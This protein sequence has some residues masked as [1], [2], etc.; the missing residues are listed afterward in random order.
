MLFFIIMIFLASSFTLSSHP[1]PGIE[2]IA[3]DINNY[4]DLKHPPQY[5]AN[6][7]MP[8][9]HSKRCTIIEN[10]D[11]VNSYFSGVYKTVSSSNQILVS[12]PCLGTDS[13]GN[14]LGAYFENIVCANRSGMHYVAVAKVWEPREKD[15]PSLFLQQLPFSIE[16]SH[17]LD[18]AAVKSNVKSLCR[19]VGSCHERSNAVWIKGLNIIRPILHNALQNYLKLSDGL[20]C[21]VVSGSDLSS[22]AVGTVLPLIPDAAIHYRC[23]D[24]YVGH[25]GFLPFRAFKET[26]PQ[27]VRTIFVLAENRDRKTR[28]KRHLAAKCDAIFPSLLAYLR[29]H[30]PEAQVVIRRG[31]DL[32]VDMAR[33]AYARHT[34]C[35]VSTFC[36]WPA[37]VNPHQ[38]HFPRTRLIVG[39][40]TSIDLGFRWL[41]SPEVLRGQNYEHAAPAQLVAKLNHDPL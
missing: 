33:L 26:I 20:N 12:T 29:K 21:T 15:V 18:E 41:L 30:F 22:M 2:Q 35:S 27:S 5:N 34:V 32:Y 14:G 37:L 36:L 16:H 17:P 31:D 28:V 9:H 19:C 23:G 10:R 4:H 7:L 40:D 13:L 1:R 3:L 38:A 25:Y 8:H 6:P 39:G 24:N 11:A